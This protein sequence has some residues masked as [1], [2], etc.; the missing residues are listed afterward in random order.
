VD[1]VKLQRFLLEF[2]DLVH[3]E[4]SLGYAEGGDTGGS[5][6]GSG[7][8]FARLSLFASSV[9]CGKEHD[10]CK[11]WDEM[12]FFVECVDNSLEYLLV[13]WPSKKAHYMSITFFAMIPPRL[14]QMNMIGRGSL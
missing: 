11:A 6:S 7:E 9:R 2:F 14:W 3:S 10:S 12:L 1:F 4:R 5:I 13:S 8:H